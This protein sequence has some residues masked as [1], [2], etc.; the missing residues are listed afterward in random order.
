MNIY[1]ADGELAFQAYP[2][3][4]R[5]EAILLLRDFYLQENQHGMYRFW[6][7]LRL[8]RAPN[9]KRKQHREKKFDFDQFDWTRYISEDALIEA[10]PT[11]YGCDPRDKDKYRELLESSIS[12]EREDPE[13][14]NCMVP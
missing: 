5:E 7:T 4:Y 14:S 12:Q 1:R 3:I 11:V 8:I 10:I 6:R 2:G 13:E 9:P